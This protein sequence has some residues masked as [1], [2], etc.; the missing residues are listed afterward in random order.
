MQS[1]GICLSGLSNNATTRSTMYQVRRQGLDMAALWQRCTR[2]PPGLPHAPFAIGT[3]DRRHGWSITWDR[4][5]TSPTRLPPFIGC[6]YQRGS[7]TRSPCCRTKS[8]RKCAP[9]PVTPRACVRSARTLRSAD[10]SRLLI[11]TT[12]LMMMIWLSKTHSFET[13]AEDPR[14]TTTGWRYHLAGRSRHTDSYQESLVIKW[15]NF[16]KWSSCASK[17]ITF[18]H[19]GYAT[20]PRSHRRQRGIR[21]IANGSAIVW[22]TTGSRW[23]RGCVYAA[24]VVPAT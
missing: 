21:P 7:R 11:P 8:S 20:V 1:I 2:W 13:P 15:W 12:V 4:R 14:S 18:R 6:A 5:T 24:L 3:A 9:V 17:T 19:E 22:E 10:T 16:D 23:L